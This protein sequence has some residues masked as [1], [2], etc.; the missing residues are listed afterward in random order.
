MTEAKFRVPADQDDR[1]DTAAK[2]NGP[3]Y[4]I[5]VDGKRIGTV[6][7]VDVVEDGAALEVTADIEDPDVVRAIEGTMNAVSFVRP[8]DS[9][10][11]RVEDYPEP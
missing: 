5:D 8:E 3:R 1:F 2:I 7:R 10:S 9:E 6:R 4:L 11:G